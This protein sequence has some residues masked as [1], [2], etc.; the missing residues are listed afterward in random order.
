[1]K[2]RTISSK[3]TLPTYM[4]DINHILNSPLNIDEEELWV[5][6][7]NPVC[8]TQRLNI[9]PDSLK[10]SR[11][12]LTFLKMTCASVLK[13]NKPI[14]KSMSS[15]EIY[16]NEPARLL[17]KNQKD[18]T[19]LNYH[20]Y[21]LKRYKSSKKLAYWTYI[22]KKHFCNQSNLSISL[23]L[24]VTTLDSLYSTIEKG[25]EPAAQTR[26]HD[27]AKKVEKE[28]KKWEGKVSMLEAELKDV[29]ADLIQ[30]RDKV[31]FLLLK[32]SICS[33]TKGIRHL[34]P[35][36]SLKV[37]VRVEIKWTHH[38]KQNLVQSLLHKDCLLVKELLIDQNF[39]RNQ[40]M[41]DSS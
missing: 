38:H 27:G 10:F 18:H 36:V 30:E 3:K 6:M 14:I 23:P 16:I 28:I 2:K 26:R 31:R 11:A 34:L 35:E 17:K 21:G 8:I 4:S 29:R 37:M 22:F 12:A 41:P 15:H 25:I 9:T 19:S 1:M 13:F 39:R 32:C 33:R 7:T 20:F 40:D 5:T 24:V